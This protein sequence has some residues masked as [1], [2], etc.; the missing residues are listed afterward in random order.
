MFEF[1]SQYKQTVKISDLFQKILGPSLTGVIWS[2]ILI[3]V[4]INGLQ[5]S[6]V[7]SEIYFYWF[8]VQAITRWHWQE[9][10]SKMKWCLILT[11]YVES[12]SFQPA[13]ATFGL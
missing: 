5:M 13:D 12:S 3:L 4:N 8:L 9:S 7:Q 2:F 6:S 11:L 10:W 1:Y